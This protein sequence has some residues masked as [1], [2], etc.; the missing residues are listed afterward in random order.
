MEQLDAKVLIVDDE[1][2]F[3]KTF[4]ERLKVRG[5]RI[6]T[7]GTGE[8][9]IARAHGKKFDAIV[10][11]LVMPGIG[12]IETLRR[13]REENPDLQIIILTGHATVDKSVEAMKGGAADFLE[14]PLDINKLMEK[15]GEA[16][17]KRVLLVEKKAEDE[18]KDIVHRK[19]W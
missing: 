11:D 16:Q 13:L 9:A 5:L 19:G 17:R 7:A 8:E 6:D 10:L 18:V 4:A 12:G 15:I 1:E 2:Q 3:L 14:K